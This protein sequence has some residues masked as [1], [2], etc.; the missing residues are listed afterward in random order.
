MLM[1]PLFLRVCLL[2]FV[3][4]DIQVP[5]VNNVCSL[6]HTAKHQHEIGG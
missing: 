2:L 1:K 5:I 3:N 4:K 6:E